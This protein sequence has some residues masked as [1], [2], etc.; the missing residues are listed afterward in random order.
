MWQLPT[1]LVLCA[2]YHKHKICSFKNKKENVSANKIPQKP[3]K[4]IL[5]RPFLYEWS[6]GELFINLKQRTS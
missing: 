5:L 4:T 6:L 1:S 3:Y 2:A